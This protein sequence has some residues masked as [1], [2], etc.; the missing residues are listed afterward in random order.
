[1]DSS[2]DSN[3]PNGLN[4]FSS[5]DCKDERE[6]QILLLQ[7]QNQALQDVNK[8]YKSELDDIRYFSQIELENLQHHI[9]NLQNVSRYAICKLYIPKAICKLKMV[10]CTY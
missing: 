4:E 6:R 1:M 3:I 8:R 7:Q 5:N 9:N 10:L 2:S